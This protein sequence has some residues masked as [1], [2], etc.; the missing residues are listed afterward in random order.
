[1][2]KLGKKGRIGQTELNLRF[3]PRFCCG[4]KNWSF[5]FL[6]YEQAFSVGMLGFMDLESVEKRD[7][8][9]EFLFFGKFGKKRKGRWLFWCKGG[10]KFNWD[11]M[12]KIN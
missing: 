10:K 2:E 11:N 12:Y 8:V 9:L 4:G 6:A 3:L 5:D 7:E 1:M